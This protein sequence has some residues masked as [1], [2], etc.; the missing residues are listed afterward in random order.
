MRPE[1]VRDFVLRRGLEMEGAN[2]S[3][4]QVPRV[5]TSILRMR[6]RSGRKLQKIARTGTDTQVRAA[7]IAIG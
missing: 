1:Y 3:Q 2:H 5:V 6:R 4:L 7:Y